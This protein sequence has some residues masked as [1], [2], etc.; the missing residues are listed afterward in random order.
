MVFPGSEVPDDGWDCEV[1]SGRSERAREEGHSA[2]GE[3][4]FTVESK[5]DVRALLTGQ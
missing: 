2:E 3:V 4:G 5:S 1:I